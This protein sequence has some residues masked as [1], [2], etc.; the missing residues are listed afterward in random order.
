MKMAIVVLKKLLF[1]ILSKT[2]GCARN[3]P[4]SR[5]SS[6][7]GSLPRRFRLD[8]CAVCERLTR[9]SRRRCRRFWYEELAQSY[10]RLSGLWA[11]VTL[12]FNLRSKSSFS[13]FDLS[14]LPYFNFSVYN[15]IIITENAIWLIFEIKEVGIRIGR[16]RAELTLSRIYVAS[17]SFF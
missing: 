9:L 4:A 2:A 8:R 12:T 17:K 5:Q 7:V 11:A 10:G 6:R 13:F 3:E 15:K 14:Y 16:C 1:Y